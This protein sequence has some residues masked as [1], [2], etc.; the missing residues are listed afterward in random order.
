MDPKWRIYFTFSLTVSRGFQLKVS[1][2]AQ[3]TVTHDQIYC[4][5][6]VKHSLI[7]L[8]KLRAILEPFSRDDTSC[9][10]RNL[11][12]FISDPRYKKIAAIIGRYNRMNTQEAF[13]FNA[14]QTSMSFLG[15]SV[16]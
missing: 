13:V 14:T 15:W 12:H 3:Q 5:L 7:L 9:Y 8:E 10:L 2:G 16:V 6:A 4:V 11:L 1:E